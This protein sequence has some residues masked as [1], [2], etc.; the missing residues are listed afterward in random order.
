LFRVLCFFLVW[1]LSSYGCFLVVFP[2][3]SI[4]L[5]KER[6]PCMNVTDDCQCFMETCTG[7][8]AKAYTNKSYQEK[9]ERYNMKNENQCIL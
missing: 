5:C 1:F 2:E 3:F 9:K 7:D 4:V 8:L 6:N